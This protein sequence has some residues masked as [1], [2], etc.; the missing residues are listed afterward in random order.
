MTHPSLKNIFPP[1]APS[2][3]LPPADSPHITLEVATSTEK[4]E[5]WLLNYSAW[6]ENRPLAFYLAKEDHLC[7]QPLTKDGG[8]THW[9]LVDNESVSSDDKNVDGLHK[10]R[11]GTLREA[12]VCC[13]CR[14]IIL[15]F[16]NLYVTCIADIRCRYCVP[17]FC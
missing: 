12:V 16:P 4:Y 17:P 15:R 2:I 8:I 5:T 11:Q 10:R 3:G 1:A 14:N 7:S 13:L 6:G 9:V